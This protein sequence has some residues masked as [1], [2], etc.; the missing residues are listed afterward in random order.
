MTFQIVG[1]GEILWDIFPDGP[2]FGG[3]PANF[4]CSAAE[5]AKSSANVSMLSAVRN[6]ELGQAAISALQERGVDTTSVQISP[7]P[8]G[9]V[10]VGLDVTGT[11]SYRFAEDSAWDHLEW[12]DRLRK[13]AVNCDAVCFGTLGQRSEQ[14]RDSIRKFIGEM[15]A[16]ALRILDVNLRSPFF[17]EDLILDSL[18]RANVLKLNETELRLIAA[19]TNCHGTP[20]ETMQKL[21]RKYQLRSVTLTLGADGA[22]LLSDG[23]VSELPGV[24]VSVVDTVG[25]GDAFTAAMVLGLLS[26]VNV[27]SINRFAMRVASYVCSQRG[28][29]MAF[30]VDLRYEI[31]H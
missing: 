1:I 4:A 9:N 29:T 16:S 30:P 19:S 23:I 8:T 14:S 2:R 15:P 22:I 7:K 26:G 31:S 25:A 3:A 20:V 5:L 18:S 24:P 11:A 27:E 6:D 17:S 28:A 12:N 10:M 21:A 13:L